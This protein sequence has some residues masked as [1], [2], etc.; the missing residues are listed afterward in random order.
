M[1]LAASTGIFNLLGQEL[2]G[3]AFVRDY[4][5]FHFDG[6][7]LRSLTSPKF[8]A[9]TGA[10]S[11]IEVASCEDLRSLI[12]HRI[13][14]IDAIDGEKIELLFEKKSKIII[15]LG[16]ENNKIGES[17]HFMLNN[18]GPIEVW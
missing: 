1:E 5:E 10:D 15:L 13:S 3:V 9:S 18:N 11:N 16:N 4:I 7:V 12:G 14:N 6:M 17:A 8:A 2:S